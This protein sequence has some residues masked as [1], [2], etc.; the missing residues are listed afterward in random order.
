MKK[1]LF[2]FTTFL[3]IFIL[4]A[5]CNFGTGFTNLSGEIV[6]DV[7]NV[8]DFD[9]LN[10]SSGINLIL[11]QGTSQKLVVKADKDLLDD[12]ITTVKGGVLKIY[13]ERKFWRDSN[14]T[15]EVTFVDLD[16]LSAS[17]GSNVKCTEGL[18]FDNLSLET[19]SGCNMDITVKASML[20]V[21]SNSGA[22]VHMDGITNQL[23]VHASSGANVKLNN[24]E[25]DI[26]S[27]SSSSGSNI[28]VIARHSIEVHSSSGSNIYVT[29]NPEKQIIS[30]SSG[31]DVHFR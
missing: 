13:C 25:A 20:D 5:A 1:Q 9:G 21:S 29:G 22:N 30:T 8:P 23:E 7:R 17:A 31:A 28:Y 3:T 16:N 24:L 19:S 14:I 10:V 4:S 18:K 15:V 26:V 12:V 27:V 11:S 6:T 2:I